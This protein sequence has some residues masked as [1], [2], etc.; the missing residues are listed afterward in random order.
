MFSPG[1]MRNRNDFV[2]PERPVYH[3]VISTP[4]GLVHKRQAKKNRKAQ[5]SDTI[6]N[7]RK[8]CLHKRLPASA[9]TTP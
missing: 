9:K 6:A 3:R 8:D 7:I 5:K 4:Y 1:K 2:Y